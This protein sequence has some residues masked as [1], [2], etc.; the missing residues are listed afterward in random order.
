MYNLIHPEV[1]GK[2]LD[3]KLDRILQTGAEVVVM[4]NPGCLLQIAAGLRRRGSPVRTVHT[5]ELLD[6]A[7]RGTDAQPG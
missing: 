6:L 1:A 2:L 3:R 5:V 4:G 7:Y